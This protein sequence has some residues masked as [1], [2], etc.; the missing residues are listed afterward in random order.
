VPPYDL[1][2]AGG[3]FCVPAKWQEAPDVCLGRGLDAFVDDQT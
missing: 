2:W 1:L 3:W